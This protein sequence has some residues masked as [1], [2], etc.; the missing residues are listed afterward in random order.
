MLEGKYLILATRKFASENRRK[1]WGYTLS[2]LLLLMVFLTAT[3]INV[4]IL[5]KIFCSILS[6]LL[7]V[8]MFA[9]YHDYLHEAILQRSPFAKGLFTFFGIYV[10]APPRIWK[11]SH[12]YHHKYNSKLYRSSIGSYPVYTKARF[13]KCSSKE[14]KQYLFVRHPMTILFGY[15]F[16]FLFGM[17]IQPLLVNFK[18]HLDSFLALLFHF[19]IQFFLLY[20]SGWQA[21]L[22]FSI[23]PHFIA[24]AIGAYLFYVQHNF[25]GVSF[26]GD[27]K[28]TYEG[29]ALDSS[30]YMELNPFLKWVTAN[31]GY[32]H[33]HHLNARI[34]FYRLSEVMDHYEELQ[35][36]KKTT[37]KP[38]DIA[39]CLRLKVW[40][41]EKKQMTGIIN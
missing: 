23:I 22:F 17:C 15:I 31:I 24:S 20:F 16:T 14:K 4:N 12:G 38:G 7:I 26:S 9:I 36:P 32:H 8:R 30:S 29:A 35:H 10:L 18:K 6:G 19:S 25:P 1:S 37:L 39:A 3:I 2:T 5:F 41:H 34:P 21:L 33:I 28:W 27:E 11:R 13:E 40:D